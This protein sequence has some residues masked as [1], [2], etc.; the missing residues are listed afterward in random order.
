M[1]YPPSPNFP[2]FGK[3]PRKSFDEMDLLGV[4]RKHIGQQLKNGWTNKNLKSKFFFT[5]PQFKH[6]IPKMLRL[7]PVMH[8]YSMLDR[9]KSPKIEWVLEV[10][11]DFSIRL[12]GGR[13]ERFVH[14]F[15]RMPILQSPPFEKLFANRCEA[16]FGQKY[17]YSE[18]S[19]L[20]H[21]KTNDLFL[22]PRKHMT[23]Y[24]RH[25]FDWGP[26]DDS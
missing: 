6:L 18:L 17:I 5:P 7:P 26:R 4:V 2:P 10:V 15:E 25:M 21:L 23:Q 19:V 8:I 13:T 11:T 22:L 20:I 12:V 3:L 24:T 1:L 9:A 14:D 16:P